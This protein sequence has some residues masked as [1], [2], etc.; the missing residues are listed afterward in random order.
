MEWF[1]IAFAVTAGWRMDIS[2][3]RSSNDFDRKRLAG[4]IAQAVPV[5]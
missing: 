1:T 3:I 2:R 5:D 4:C